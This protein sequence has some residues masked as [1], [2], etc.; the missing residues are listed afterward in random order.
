M[1]SAQEHGRIGG[2]PQVHK[3]FDEGPLRFSPWMWLVRAASQARTCE[4]VTGQHR[5]AQTTDVFRS[6]RSGEFVIIA[7]MAYFIEYVTVVVRIYRTGWIFYLDIL[8]ENSDCRISKQA[9]FDSSR[10]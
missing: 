3:G 4:A 5:V 10:H 6:E 8:P 2:I 7:T 9:F 1:F